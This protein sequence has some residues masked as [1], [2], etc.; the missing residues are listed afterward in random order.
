MII[1]EAVK[2]MN[3]TNVSVDAEEIK[4]LGLVMN[5]ILQDL[6]KAV[7]EFDKREE[8]SAGMLAYETSR[9]WGHLNA[10]T[11]IVID[12]AKSINDELVDL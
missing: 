10:L 2:E 6:E 9:V 11:N 7:V 1:M 8:H 4:Q 3:L 5:D 12:K